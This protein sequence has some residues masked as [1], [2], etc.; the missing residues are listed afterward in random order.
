[1]KIFFDCSEMGF[2]VLPHHICNLKSENNIHMWETYTPWIRL[3]QAC[4]HNGVTI[5]SGYLLIDLL[6]GYLS[7]VL[8]VF[9]FRSF[10]WRPGSDKGSCFQ[11][12]TTHNITQLELSRKSTNHFD[13]GLLIRFV[14]LHSPDSHNTCNIDIQC[15]VTLISVNFSLF[16]PENLANDIPVF[17]VSQLFLQ[18]CEDS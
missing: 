12:E 7:A 15:A 4:C 18:F 9:D 17:N 3:G 13:V 8:L 6:I 16:Y 5:K 2:V 11:T 1:M 10:S 14:V